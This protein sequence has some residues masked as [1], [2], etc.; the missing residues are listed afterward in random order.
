MSKDIRNIPVLD[1]LR[2]VAILMV[3][4]WHSLPCQLLGPFHPGTWQARV[5]KYLDTTW[6]GV[7]LFFVLSGFL[8]FRLFL[9]NR[10]SPR[11]LAGFYIRRACRI[12]PL[13]WILLIA[14]LFTARIIPNHS[15][16]SWILDNPMPSWSYWALVQNWLMGFAGHVGCHWLGITWS[17]AAEEQFYLMAPLIFL[18]VRISRGA[19]ILLVLTLVPIL[20][21]TQTSSFHAFV[22]TFYRIDA[23]FLG[24]LA[25]YLFDN[26]L[27]RSYLKNHSRIVSVPLA[28]CFFLLVYKKRNPFFTFSGWYDEHVIHGLFYFC[29]IL[30]LVLHHNW[31]SKIVSLS[32]FRELGRISYSLYLIHELVAGV[33]HGYFFSSQPLL[34][35]SRQIATTCAGL[36]L[37]F[38][39]SKILYRYVEAPFIKWGRLWSSNLSGNTPLPSSNPNS[40]Q[41]LC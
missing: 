41:V 14:F 27:I 5:M 33:L 17:L 11:Y 1:G 36:V 32:I 35:S 28:L 2:G 24:A 12:L 31:L 40:S 9:T 19:W 8:I 7:D 25:S 21:R 20:L 4:V 39:F 29:L 13:Y 34:S 15:S 23:F 30:S 16:F 18:L 38:L 6:S 26:N 10:F 3:L 37:S 22:G